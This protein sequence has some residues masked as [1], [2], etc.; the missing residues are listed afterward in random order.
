MGVFGIAALRLKPIANLIVTTLTVIRFSR[1]SITRL[2]Q[3]FKHFDQLDFKPSNPY[4]ENTT[5][6]P[7][8]NKQRESHAEIFRSLELKN[9]SYTYPNSLRKALHNISLEITVGESVG[10]VGPSGAGKTTI[11][12]IIL[13][14][15]EPSHGQIYFNSLPLEECLKEWRSQVAYLPQQ[16]FLID[17]TLR[18][19][20]ALGVEDEI[21]D[22][23]KIH[24]SIRKARLKDLVEQLPSGLNT[25]VGERGIRLSGGQRQRVALARAFYHKRSVLVLDEATSALDHETELEITEE[26]KQ[27]KGS[28]TL[29]VIAHRLTTVQHCD[30]IFKLN[31][32]I[33][34]DYGSSAQIL[35]LNESLNS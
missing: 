10:F 13:G 6:R 1:D 30:K 24:E 31:N 27:L 32:G 11:V 19:N 4:Y 15:L 29:I 3:D 28:T 22:E 5:N 16:V 14:L 23:V 34:V 20:V 35:N 7:I 18:R 2:H 21:I 25:I 33:L 9:L 26:I 12:D 8:T 17:N